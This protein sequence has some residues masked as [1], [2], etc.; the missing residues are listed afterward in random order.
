MIHVKLVLRTKPETVT[1][2]IICSNKAARH[3]SFSG[4]AEGTTSHTW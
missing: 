1:E 4:Q 2:S 3:K